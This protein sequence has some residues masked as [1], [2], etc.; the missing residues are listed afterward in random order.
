MADY[1]YGSA[2]VRVLETRLIGRERIRLLTDEPDVASVWQRLA[3]YGVTPVSDANGAILR[4]ETL[5]AILRRV[6]ADV[7]EM[8]P[9]DRLVRLWLYPYDCNNVKAAIKGFARS[10]DPRSMMFD[11]GT[12]EIERVIEMVRTNDYEGLSPALAAAAVTASESYA[13]TGNPQTVDLTLDRACYADMLSAASENGFCLELIKRKIDLT[14]LLSVIRVLRMRSGAAGERLLEEALIEGGTLSV[15]LLLERYG[16][17]EEALWKFLQS[18]VYNGFA[19]RQGEDSSLTEIERSAD[20]EWLAKLDEIKFV[21]YGAE[22]I[23]AYLITVEC[24]VRNLRMILAGKE[25]GLSAAT[26]RERIRDGY[27]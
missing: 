21:P 17:G 1:L 6:Y 14:N 10:I 23:I 16:L 18:S 15:E 26:I 2:R 11:F 24:E 22:V 3:E 12:V 9:E 25:A 20:R 4:E 5:L 7:C 13:K 19:F 8:L 27:V